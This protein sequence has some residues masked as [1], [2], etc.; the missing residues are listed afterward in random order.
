MVQ[1]AIN[2]AI[3]AANLDIDGVIGSKTIE[4]MNK[5]TPEQLRAINNTI[6][7]QREA[8]YRQLVQDDPTQ[9]RF[10]K[11]WLNRAGEFRQ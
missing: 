1:K 9:A 11:G 5:A 8:F 4:A 7:D 6:A 2:G 10:L 3:P